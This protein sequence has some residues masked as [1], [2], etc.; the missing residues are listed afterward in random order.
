MAITCAQVT[1]VQDTVV[2]GILQAAAGVA[3]IVSH[4]LQLTEVGKNISVVTATVIL[5]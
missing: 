4:V 5:V 1:V 3:A 2:D